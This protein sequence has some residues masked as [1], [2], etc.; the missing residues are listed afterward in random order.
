[1][2]QDYYN[3]KGKIA[4]ITGG[5]NGIGL[6]LGMLFSKKGARV[7][8]LDAVPPKK[9]A[10]GVQFIKADVTNS[11][12]IKRAFQKIGGNGK[13]DILVNNAGIM[14]R[15]EIFD[16]PEKD[17]DD[18]FRLNLKGYW[19]VAKAAQGV[20]KKN[21]HLL[22]I[23]SVHGVNLP[24][25]PALYGLTKKAVCALA[26]I[27]ARTYPRYRIKIIAPGPIAT[28]MSKTGRTT[29]EYKKRLA[30]QEQPE[31]LCERICAL[32]GSRHT[33]LLYSWRTS[34]YSFK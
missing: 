18:L 32:I 20:L 2:L 33:Q 4:V 25:N 9:Q 5:S 15:G 19:L 22:F 6:A 24:K 10:Q 11:G 8:S 13:V 26:E 14:R 30:Q 23:S 21:A 17:W 1:M 16:S 34:S 7:F 31:Q 29:A 3:Y 12:Q 28:S 27:I